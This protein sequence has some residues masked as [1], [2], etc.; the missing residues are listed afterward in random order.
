MKTNYLPI[1][2]LLAKIS[3]VAST[4]EFISASSIRKK[5]WSPLAPIQ[6][7]FRPY[8]DP[9]LGMGAGF[10]FQYG[11]SKMGRPSCPF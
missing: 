8:F 10:A 4:W 1:M 9:M 3:D 11:T 6:V 7:A 2:C 5:V